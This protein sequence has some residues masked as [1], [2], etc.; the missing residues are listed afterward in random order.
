MQR[1]CVKFVTPNRLHHPFHLMKRHPHAGNT[2]CSKIEAGGPSELDLV[3]ARSNN[4]GSDHSGLR[5]AP[6]PLT[7]CPRQLSRVGSMWHRDRNHNYEVIDTTPL[8]HRVKRSSPISCA[9]PRTSPDRSRVLAAWGCAFAE[10]PL[11][12]GT[13]RVAHNSSDPLEGASPRLTVA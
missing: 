2:G 13:M 10:K 7:G 4:C 9:T 8:W 1:F 6:R 11:R 5:C 12:C 3:D